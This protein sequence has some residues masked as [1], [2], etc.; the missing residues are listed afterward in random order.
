MGD[1]IQDALKKST[2]G[3]FGPVVCLAGN[4]VVADIA[5]FF[6]D[7]RIMALARSPAVLIVVSRSKRKCVVNVD[8]VYLKVVY[9]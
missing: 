6:A 2:F 8:S 3:A 4:E 1:A 5:A 7:A 9:F